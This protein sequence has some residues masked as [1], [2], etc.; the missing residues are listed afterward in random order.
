MLAVVITGPVVVNY[1]EESKQRSPCWFVAG[2]SCFL[3]WLILLSGR[4]SNHHEEVL[5]TWHLP[6]GAEAPKFQ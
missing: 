1:A 2:L 6:L 3:L 4:R 5:T